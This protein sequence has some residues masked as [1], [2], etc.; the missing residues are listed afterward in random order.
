M[1]TTAPIMV[2]VGQV[3]GRI[4]EV[5]VTPGSTVRA[6]LETAGIQGDASYTITINNEPAA[7]DDTVTSGDVAILLTRKIRGAVDPIMVKVGQVPGRIQEVAVT[8]G[9]TVRSI[10]ETAGIQGDASYT[11]TINNEPAALEDTVTSGDVAI[12]LTR[13]IRGAN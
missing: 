12:L 5:A 7:L 10:L 11:I 1:T 2:K 4:Q 13:K 3:P 8:P 9:S 6:I